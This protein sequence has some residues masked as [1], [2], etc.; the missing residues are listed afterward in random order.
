MITK[1]DLIVSILCTFCLTTVLLTMM[2][3]QS[4]E[5]D[6]WTDVTEDGRI[7][8]LDLIKVAGNLGTMGDTT[9]NVNVMNWPEANQQTVF[10]GQTT[11]YNS[12][13]YNASGFSQI[14]L[15][16]TVSGLSGLEYV[17]FHMTSTIQDP[18]GS[19]Q[20]YVNFLQP[21]TATS[22]NSSGALTFSVPAAK[23]M[24]YVTFPGGTTA[25]AYLAFYLTYA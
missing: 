6:P 7:N 25:A 8:V 11:S 3:V 18:G 17:L 21:F 14:H 1:K 24:F 12:Q 15:T 20:V 4:A 10:Y 5:W 22:T 2:P 23:F 19:G 16:W 13:F 9:K